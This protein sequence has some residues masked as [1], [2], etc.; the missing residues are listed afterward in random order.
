MAAYQDKTLEEIA[1][2]D[3]DAAMT[4]IGLDQNI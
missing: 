4:Q 1:A 3:I 2:T